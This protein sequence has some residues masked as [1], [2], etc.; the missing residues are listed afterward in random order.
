MGGNKVSQLL[1]ETHYIIFY[2][3]V[4]GK[5]VQLQDQLEKQSRI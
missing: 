3:E 5:N 2:I 1:K 4:G